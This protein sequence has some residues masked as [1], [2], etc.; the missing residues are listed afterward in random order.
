[1]VKVAGEVLAYCSQC[2]MDLTAAVVAM[3][4][5]Q[6]VRVMCK[7][8]RKERAYKSPKGVTDPGKAP[9]AKTTTRGARTD[10]GE[11]V[12]YSVG[13]EWRKAMAKYAQAKANPYSAKNPVGVNDKLIHPTFG[14][15]IVTKLIHPNKAEILFE[16]DLKVLICGGHRT[17]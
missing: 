11:R 1:M 10:T 8:C 4:G 9:P 7:T 17:G 14:E 16:M 5:D 2:K 3:R 15:G 13:A 12:D 6:I